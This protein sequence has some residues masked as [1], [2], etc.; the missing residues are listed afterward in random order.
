M[1]LDVFQNF[2]FC[3]KVLI[4]SLVTNNI[5]SF[6]CEVIGFLFNFETMSG[7]YLSLNNCSVAVALLNKNDVPR[8]KWLL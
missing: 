4:V 5:I 3:F 2:H 1:V 6:P 7:K 8:K